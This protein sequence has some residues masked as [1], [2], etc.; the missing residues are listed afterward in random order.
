MFNPKTIRL[1]LGAAGAC[2]ALYSNAQLSIQ[3]ALPRFQETVHLTAPPGAIGAPYF[4]SSTLVSMSGNTVTVS[5]QMRGAFFPEEVIAPLDVV[6]G[7]FPQGSYDV[8]VLKVTEGLPNSVA[9]TAHFDVAA[10]NT[11]ASAPMYDYSD[12]WWNS[13][14]SGWGISLTQHPSA[15]LFAAWFVYGSDGKPI[16]YVIPNGT[17]LTTPS[18]LFSDGVSQYSG[19]VYRTRGPYYGGSFDPSQ[20]MVTPVGSGNLMFTDYSHAV[21]S[22]TVDGVT[23]SKTIERQPF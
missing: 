18:G 7:K 8:N 3:P 23:G 12:M 4:T 17:W 9:G 11:Q 20:V 10:R 14:E 1:V 5:V 16:W 2:S 15:N 21:F 6:L 19:A 22:Y 13:A